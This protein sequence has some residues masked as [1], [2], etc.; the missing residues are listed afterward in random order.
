VTKQ[1]EEALALLKITMQTQKEQHE[2]AI[3]ELKEKHDADIATLRKEFD[4]VVYN[5]WE[6][7]ELFR[8]PVHEK[9]CFMETYIKAPREAHDTM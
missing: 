7:L 9:K 5:V 2:Q 1:L 3:V 4:V 8:K 6:Y